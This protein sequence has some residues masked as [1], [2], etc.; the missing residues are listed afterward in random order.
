MKHVPEIGAK[1]R[2]Q[3]TGSKFCSM[4]ALF[5][6]PVDFIDA[7]DLHQSVQVWCIGEINRWIKQHTPSDMQFGSKIFLVLVF[8]NK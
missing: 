6:S 4:G 2:Y 8:G 5:Y 7:S 1:N 3:K